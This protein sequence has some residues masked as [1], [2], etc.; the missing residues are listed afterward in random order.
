MRDSLESDD[1]IRKPILRIQEEKM[2]IL[3][4]EM[5]AHNRDGFRRTAKSEA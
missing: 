2:G 4:P 3:W 5:M 1:Q